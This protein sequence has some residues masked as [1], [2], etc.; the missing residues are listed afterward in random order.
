MGAKLIKQ[1]KWTFIT[2]DTHLG[3]AEGALISPS[4]KIIYTYKHLNELFWMFIFVD[5][6]VKLSLFKN[7]EVYKEEEPYPKVK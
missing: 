7:W 5:E 2:I 4:P 3:N 1:Y 6:N